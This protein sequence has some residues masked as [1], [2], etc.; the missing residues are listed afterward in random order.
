MF[1]LDSGLFWF[2]QGIFMCLAVLG[3]KAWLA[4][5]GLRVPFWKWPLI[6]GWI[7]FVGVAIAY[8]G[9]SLGEGEPQAATI[10]GLLAGTAA[11]ISGAVLWRVLRWG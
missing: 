9:T 3:L 8:V 5:K 6:V 4:D 2:V 7:L 11:A 10:G 1:V